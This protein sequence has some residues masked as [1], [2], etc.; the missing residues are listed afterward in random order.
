MCIRSHVKS[1]KSSVVNYIWWYWLVVLQH[2]FLHS[3]SQDV[4]LVA[5]MIELINF[6]VSQV[7]VP[8]HNVQHVGLLLF[9]V[10]KW[11]SLTYLNRGQWIV[12]SDSVSRCGEFQQCQIV[13]SFNSLMLWEVSVA[14]CCEEFHIAM[15]SCCENF[16]LQWHHATRSFN[17]SMLQ[18]VSVASCYAEFL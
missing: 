14:S 13:R 8:V 2:L 18:E 5:Q 12:S 17:S 11:W 4:S 7:H 6:F 3:I 1:K 16:Q 15:A 9:F 10:S